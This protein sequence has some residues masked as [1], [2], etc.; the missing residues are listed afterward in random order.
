LF[1]ELNGGDTVEHPVAAERA[2]PAK[3]SVASSDVLDEVIEMA[4]V[5]LS[6]LT[7]SEIVFS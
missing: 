5:G 6:R 7:I 1:I 3:A 4:S 2:T